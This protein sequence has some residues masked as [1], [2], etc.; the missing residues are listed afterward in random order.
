MSTPSERLEAEVWLETRSQSCLA[1]RGRRSSLPSTSTT[2]RTPPPSAARTSSR[3]SARMTARSPASSSKS[4][5]TS[6]EAPRAPAPRSTCPD[7]VLVE[8]PP[9]HRA[10]AADGSPFAAGSARP[11]PVP[12][13]DGASTALA[14]RPP[15]QVLVASACAARRGRLGPAVRGTDQLSHGCSAPRGCTVCSRTHAST[16]SRR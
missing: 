13:F 14:C 12:A 10:D 9:P 2:P 1:P 6:P 5:G 15:D 8:R 11:R 16:S 4:S 3:L 7:P